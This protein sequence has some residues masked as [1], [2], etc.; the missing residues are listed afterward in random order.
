MTCCVMSRTAKLVNHNL[1]V[2]SEQLIPDTK[3]SLLI[4]LYV[5]QVGLDLA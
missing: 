5:D 3:V 1:S 2:C 4:N